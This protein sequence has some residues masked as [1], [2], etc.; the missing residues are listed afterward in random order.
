MSIYLYIKQQPKTKLKYFGKTVQDPHT[1]NGSGVYWIRH[2]RKH[3]KPITLEVWEF[4]D[5]KQ[6]TKFALEF[7]DRNNIVKS[8]EWDNMIPE[9]GINIPPSQKGK[10]QTVEHIKKSVAAR[11][12][13]KRSRAFCQLISEMKKGI[14]I[15]PC[16]E[17]HK[18]K[19][20]ATKIGK[21]WFTNKERNL[22]KLCYPGTE[23]EGWVVGTKIR[24]RPQ[25]GLTRKKRQPKLIQ[26]TL[27]S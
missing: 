13:A 25:A 14:K 27:L 26:A 7:S 6:C 9:D 22:Q 3:G 20:A 11:I 10:K 16:S 8:K 24:K 12:G 19:I 5:Q 21:F 1:Y 2:C 17:T 15:A 18:Q 23:P 4:Q